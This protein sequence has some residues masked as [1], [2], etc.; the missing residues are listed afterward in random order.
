M[1]FENTNEDLNILFNSS[2]MRCTTQQIK[3]TFKDIEDGE[4]EQTITKY[5][6][7]E[8]SIC[9][10][11]FN[12]EENVAITNCGHHACITCMDNCLEQSRDC[13]KCRQPLLTISTIE[14]GIIDLNEFQ[15]NIRKLSTI[16]D[17]S[18]TPQRQVTCSGYQGNGN[19]NRL[20]RQ[21]TQSSYSQFDSHDDLRQNN[22]MIVLPSLPITASIQTLQNEDSSNELV[23]LHTKKTIFNGTELSTL[24]LI[25]PFVQIV[26]DE[27]NI[28]FII[29][30][31]GSMSCQNRIKFCKD[32]LF[33]TVKKLKSNQRITIITFDDY[34]VQ[35]IPLGPVNSLN[36]D[37]IN[38]KIDKISAIGGTNYNIAFEH[39]IKILCEGNN[40]VF[41]MTDREPSQTTD[42]SILERLYS[43]YPTLIIYIISMG[44]DV[45]ATKNLLPL[46]YNRSDELGI[47]MHFNTFDSF[48]PFIND[49]VGSSTSTFATNIRLKFEGCIPISSKCI[50]ED[51]FVSLTCGALQYN[52]T[53]QFAYTIESD[54]DVIITIYYEID[55]T[56]YE[57]ISKLDE[58]DILGV[59]LNTHFPNK[60]FIDRRVNEIRLNSSFSKKQKKEQLETI[61]LTIKEEDL[62]IFYEEFT[63]CLRLLIDDIIA[64]STR[65]TYNADN[66]F[67]QSQTATVSRSISANISLRSASQTQRVH[68]ED[69]IEEEEIVEEM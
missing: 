58:D 31:S 2:T 49:I 10:D 50:Y 4:Q 55:G 63:K 64:L 21:S 11:K 43:A 56:S 22:H 27:V 48:V 28:Y 61:L 60:R 9:G 19:T 32:A 51:G 15:Q 12:N 59:E 36:I 26:N 45:D 33:E 1:S 16:F 3:R 66:S 35:E 24:A 39:L 40:I 52:N 14:W 29:D 41:F 17:L 62:G 42:L 8:C 47:Y 54:R 68:F 25:A 57:V 44:S 46:L 20:M 6:D 67:L 18:N 65:R 7:S 38:S 30:V 34:S 37:E 23:C 53:L 5:L 13:F 69:I